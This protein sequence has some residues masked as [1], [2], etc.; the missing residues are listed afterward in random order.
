MNPLVTQC[1]FRGN[2]LTLAA[3]RWDPRPVKLPARAM[4]AKV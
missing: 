1:E 3:D 4:T 2:D